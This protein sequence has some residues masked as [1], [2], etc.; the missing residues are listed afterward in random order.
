MCEIIKPY[1][2]KYYKQKEVLR[3]IIGQRKKEILL[4]VAKVNKNQCFKI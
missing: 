3:I 2:R 1:I 4:S